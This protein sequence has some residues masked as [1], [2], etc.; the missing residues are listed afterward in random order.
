MALNRLLSADEVAQLLGVS[1]AFVLAHSNGNRRPKLPSVKLGK[2][3]KFQ[4]EAIEKF[5]E[6]CSR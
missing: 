4:A 3:V 2:L 6:E 1:R 5:I